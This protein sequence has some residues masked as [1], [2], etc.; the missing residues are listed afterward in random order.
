[1]LQNTLSF[2]LAFVS[3]K[4]SAIK[5]SEPDGFL[6]AKFLADFCHE[7]GKNGRKPANNGEMPKK[8]KRDDVWQFPN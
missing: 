1:L 3:Q 5:F 8:E 2:A 6:G 4:H 7:S